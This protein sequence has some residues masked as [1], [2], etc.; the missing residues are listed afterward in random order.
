LINI[1]LDIN[2]AK[3][4]AFLHFGSKRQ[5][6]WQTAFRE[7]LLALLMTPIL[8]NMNLNAKLGTVPTADLDDA[9][10]TD[11]K[12]SYCWETV[13]RESMPRITEIDVEMTT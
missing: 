12:L 3:K 2:L 10:D 6:L 5:S 4:R 8:I 13:R 1:E 7:T 11:K 9:E